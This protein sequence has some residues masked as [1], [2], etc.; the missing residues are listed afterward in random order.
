MLSDPSPLMIAYDSAQLLS[1]TWGGSQHLAV[2]QAM[3]HFEDN[4]ITW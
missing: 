1:W 3:C 4:K 2:T